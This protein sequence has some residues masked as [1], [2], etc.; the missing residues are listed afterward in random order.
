ILAREPEDSGS[1]WFAP[2]QGATAARV[3]ARWPAFPDDV[4]TVVLLERRDGEERLY[5]RSQAVLRIAALLELGHPLWW[6]ALARLPR[7]LSDAGYRAFA[8]SRYR[9]F[10]RVDSCALPSRQH[11]DRVLA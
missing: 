3:R 7:W 4:D 1:F 6:S 11:R 2:L 9:L 8:A 5:L 10:G